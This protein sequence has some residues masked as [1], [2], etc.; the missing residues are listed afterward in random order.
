MKSLIKKIIILVIVL[1]VGYLAYSMFF[2][3]A[4][5][6]NTLISGSNGL[7]GRNIADT[8]VLGSQITQAL[9]QI[10]SLNL[11]GSIFNNPIFQSLIDKSQP[12]N[13]QP[14]G[15]RNPF[16]PLADTSVN[17]SIDSQNSITIPQEA[18]SQTE[19]S[20]TVPPTS[21]ESESSEQAEVPT[22]L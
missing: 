21:S 14:A 4:E 5:D 8:Q 6:S 3:K 17:Y 1:V 11:D 13:P 2:K 10:E 19:T 20:Q 22:D 9:I 18:D 16:A 7:G 12:I 15:R